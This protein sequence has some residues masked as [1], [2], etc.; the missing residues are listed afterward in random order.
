M[1]DAAWGSTVQKATFDVESSG[2]LLVWSGWPRRNI[3]SLA[4]IKNLQNPGVILNGTLGKLN[5]INMVLLSFI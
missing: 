1:K 4:H 5:S 3:G 2:M